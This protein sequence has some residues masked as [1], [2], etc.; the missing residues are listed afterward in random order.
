M[1]AKSALPLHIHAA[2]NCINYFLGEWQKTR[3]RLIGQQICHS[4]K[5]YDVSAP[6]TRCIRCVIITPKILASSSVGR[7]IIFEIVAIARACPAPKSTT[8]MSGDFS[9]VT[10]MR[11][12]TAT[13][14]A[15]A[16]RFFW[17]FFCSSKLNTVVVNN[18]QLFILFVY[19]CI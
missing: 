1:S 6:C 15:C 9:L 19:I 13:P 5:L 10:C 12:S 2:I 16:F 14:L 17:F 11:I 4:R 18:Q 8:I 7:R 3:H